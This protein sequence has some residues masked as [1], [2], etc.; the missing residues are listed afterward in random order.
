MSVRRDAPAPVL[1]LAVRDEQPGRAW[2]PPGRH[3]PDARETVGGLDLVGGGTWLSV[4]GP[5][6]HCGVSAAVVING[7]GPAAGRHRRSRGDL[8]LLAA[9][10]TMAADLPVRRYDPFHLLRACRHGARLHSWDG[11]RLEEWELPDGT[12]VITN[13]GPHDVVDDPYVPPAA[14]AAEAARRAH[15]RPRLAAAPRPDPRPD[16]RHRTALAAW[17]PW[18]ALAE[19]DALPP[20]DP[21]ALVG[22]WD[23]GGGPWL[24]S[25]VS[26]VALGPDRARYD[27]GTVRGRKVSWRRV[28]VWSGA[29]EFAQVGDDVVVEA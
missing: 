13:G 24:T 4:N 10:G 5:V 27:F 17:G 8:P 9:R 7:F 19:G 11:R 12:H 14:V 26:L 16:P 3:W 15:F 22:R 1:I 20:D 23:F 29:G 25:S 18:V 28:P 2:L 21:R 6:E